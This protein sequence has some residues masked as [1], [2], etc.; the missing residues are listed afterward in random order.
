MPKPLAR[1][2][3]SQLRSQLKVLPIAGTAA[4][5]ADALHARATK[6]HK[7]DDRSSTDA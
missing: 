5:D 3:F 2:K 4:A 7:G 6:K 1:A